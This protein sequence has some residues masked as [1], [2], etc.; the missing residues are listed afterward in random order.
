MN[1]ESFKKPQ[2]EHQEK[3]SLSVRIGEA[4]KEI[5]PALAIGATVAGASF[6]GS[7]IDHFLN[8]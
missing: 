5:A 8:T 4:V 1:P 2:I 6:V 7:K 3:E